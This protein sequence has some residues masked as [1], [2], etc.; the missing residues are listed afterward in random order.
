MNI[1]A[2]IFREY[3]I[4]GVV[5]RDLTP[6]LVESLGRAIGS[7]LIARGGRVIAVGRDGRLSGLA[8]H[9][10]LA[11]GLRSVGCDVLD[12]GMV[13]TPVLSFAVQH[14]HADGGVMVTGS[15][16]PPDYNGFKTVLMG[17]TLYGEHVQNIY[18][19]LRD[20]DFASGK[21]HGQLSQYG[22]LD[23]YVQRIVSD[24]R[25]A[26]PLHIGM[27][28]GNGVTGIVA[29]EL[30]RQLGCVVHGL[31]VEV[32]GRFP[33]HPADPTDEKNLQDLIALIQRKNLDLGLAFDGDGDRLVVVSANGE[34][35]LADRLLMLFARDILPDYPGAS[36]VYDVKSTSLLPDI[37]RVAGGEPVMWKTGYSLIKTKMEELEAPVGAELAGHFFFRDRWP[38]FDDGMYAGARLLE[39]LAKAVKEG[40][41]ASNTLETL[42]K[43]PSTPEQ[44]MAMAEGEAQKVMSV[45]MREAGTLFPEARIITLD[46]LRLEFADGW[47]LIRASNT[48]PVLVTR[49][50]AVNNQLLQAINNRITRCILTQVMANTEVKISITV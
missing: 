8:F 42:P 35:I 23:A 22:V 45:L 29:P 12:V 13:P 41:T 38:G 37:I 27:D 7:E 1:P 3:D 36:V 20:Q 24:V 15:H 14:L 25:L 4:R 34:V 48:Q 33:N 5:D 2:D 19:R 46:G 28:C 50:E 47:A 21:V 17:Q 18:R 10:A 32:D 39:I 40:L 30:F 26:Q 49:F 11:M 6:E 44:R 31:Y 43:L 16:N 9:H